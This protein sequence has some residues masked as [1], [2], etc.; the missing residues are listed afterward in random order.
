M[1][2][3]LSELNARI[4]VCDPK[5][6]AGIVYEFLD[7]QNWTYYVDGQQIKEPM[8]HVLVDTAGNITEILF[9]ARMDSDMNPVSVDT[10]TG[11]QV[12]LESLIHVN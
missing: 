11:Q 2:N 12:L 7:N 3:Q 4:K 5:E 1:E 6:V 9:V 10:G 8:I